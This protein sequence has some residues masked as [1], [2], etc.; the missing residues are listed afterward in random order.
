ML[1]E[2]LSESFTDF[3]KSIKQSFSYHAP[4]ASID[5]AV[6]VSNTHEVTD[7]YWPTPEQTHDGV[8]GHAHTRLCGYSN[9]GTLKVMGWI[10]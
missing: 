4:P 1:A 7:D 6:I 3:G 2:R 9:T 10:N 8:D 5:Y